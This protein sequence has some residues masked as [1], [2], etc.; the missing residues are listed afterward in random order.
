[1][2][3]NKREQSYRK[4]GK[5]YKQTAQTGIAQK[6]IKPKGDTLTYKEVKETQIKATSL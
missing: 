3:G 1:M 5:G 6:A 4:I 2:Q